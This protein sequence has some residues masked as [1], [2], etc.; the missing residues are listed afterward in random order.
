MN[1][2]FNWS[3]Y[4]PRQNTPYGLAP[5]FELC[6][7]RGEESAKNFRM[8]PNSETILVDETAPIIWHA[9]TDSSGYLTVTPYV[10]TPYQPEQKPQIDVND[11]AE[12]VKQ[13]EEKYELQS[14]ASAKSGKHQQ[15]NQ[16]QPNDTTNWKD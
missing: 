11:L 7:V 8:A 15:R 6:K 12:R 4:M 5:H 10:I 16:Q 3:G 9:Q 2:N 14:N 13:L 1:N